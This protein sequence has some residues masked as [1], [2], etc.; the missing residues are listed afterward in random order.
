VP[1]IKFVGQHRFFFASCDGGEPPHVHIEHDGKVAKFWLQ[2]VKKAKAGR[3]SQYQLN[4]IERL[5]SEHQVEFIKAW[6]DFFGR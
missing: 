1:T 6:H 3:L 5:V 2:P 4:T